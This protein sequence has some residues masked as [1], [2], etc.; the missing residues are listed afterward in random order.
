MFIVLTGNFS[1]RDLLTVALL[2]SLLD[3]NFFYKIRNAKNKSRIIPNLFSVVLHLA[4]CYAVYLLYQFKYN[5]KVGELDVKINFTKEQFNLGLQYAVITATFL[6]SST[7]FMTIL[8]ALAKS[9]NEYSG[10]VKYGNIAK[11]VLF[12]GIALVLFSG[13]LVPIQSLHKGTNTTIQT[14]QRTIYNR[15]H[16]LRAINEYGTLFNKATGVNGRPEI[17]IE[18]SNNIEGPWL[19]Y[20]FLYKPGNV[21]H[22]LPFVGK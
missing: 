20:N 1:F 19:E 15:L 17:I 12:A 7:L 10:A 2:I 3:D 5:D 8:Q 4:V 22:S 13:G 21:N 9:A 6:G 18:G 11:T 14:P 16:K